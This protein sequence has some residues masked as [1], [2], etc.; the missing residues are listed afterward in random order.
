MEEQY[1]KARMMIYAMYLASVLVLLLPIF[2]EASIGWMH[3]QSLERLSPASIYVI[4]IWLSG[5]CLGSA[6]FYRA[7]LKRM[8][9]MF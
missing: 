9:R 7:V 3:I 6:M 1:R 4:L 8:E 2:Y 5:F